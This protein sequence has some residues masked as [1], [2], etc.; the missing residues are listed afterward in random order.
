MGTG[1][2][3]ATR[4]KLSEA[5]LPLCRYRGLVDSLLWGGDHYLLL[6]DYESYVAT[7]ARVDALY[8]DPGAWAERAIANVAGMGAF[9]S[10]R[11]IRA[12]AEQIWAIA[13]ETR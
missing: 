3:L 4:G 9:S 2:T 8:R 7:Q 5:R 10:D 13:P 1:N 12:Y 6:A 11:T